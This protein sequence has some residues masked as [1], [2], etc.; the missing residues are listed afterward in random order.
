MD[1]IDSPKT[2]IIL[3]HGNYYYNSM[4]FSLKN[5]SATYQRLMNVVFSHHIVQNLEVYIDDIILK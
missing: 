2:T 4:P 1:R 3:N 5:A